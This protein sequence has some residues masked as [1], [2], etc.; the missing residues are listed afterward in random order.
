[1]ASDLSILIQDTI[2]STLETN[3]SYSTSLVNTFHA[4]I[5][6][7]KD[8]NIIVIDAS[9]SFESITINTKFIVPAYISSFIFNTMM[10]EDVEPSL[11]VDDDI[12]DAVK[13][14]FSQV[15]GGLETTING[16]A[17]EDLGNTKFSI[18]D[19]QILKGDDYTIIHKLIIFKLLINEKKFDI[20]IDFEEPALEYLNTLNISEES[21]LKKEENNNKEI[22][23]DDTTDNISE[24]ENS[25]EVEDLDIDGL[26]V[27]DE[28]PNDN[29]EEDK[30]EQEIQ[31]SQEEE[32]QNI[33]D[34]EDKSNDDKEEKKK[35]KLKLIIMIVAGIL[36][37]VILGFATA[38]FMGVFDTAPVITKDTNKTKLPKKQNIIITQIKNKQIDFKINMINTSRLNKKL[39][40]LTKYEIMEEDALTQFKQKEKDRLYKL[41]MQRLEEFATNNKE[42]SLFNKNIQGQYSK[43]QNRFDSDEINNTLALNQQ[44][45]LDNEKLVFIQISSLRYKKYKDI[46]T[47]EK[48]KNIPISIC[49]NNQDKIDVYIG[50]IYL[51][52]IVNNIINKIKNKNDAKI[53]ILTKQEF[54]TRCDF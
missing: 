26:E 40:I 45:I 50:P 17:F 30:P 42:E 31:I 24:E 54:D 39:S 25:T 2:C 52:T 20:F 21:Q 49:K 37:C 34:G 27:A 5:D 12:A 1:M 11:E 9:F 14:V 19:F 48:T 43:K 7:L 36:V 15:C 16:S 46:I 18:G 47:K 44:K 3:L 13:E 8:L 23:E 51:K 53:V 22:E 41:K 4:S 35:K 29:N 32:G 28:E 10:M 6:D 33:E 38:Y